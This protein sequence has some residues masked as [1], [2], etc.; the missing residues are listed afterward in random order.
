MLLA[1]LKEQDNQGVLVHFRL[2]LTV[3]KVDPNLRARTFEEEIEA[4]SDVIAEL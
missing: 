4:V 1:A 3:N 2:I